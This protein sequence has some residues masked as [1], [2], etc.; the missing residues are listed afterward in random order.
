MHSREQSKLAHFLLCIP[1]VT[2][3]PVLITLHSNHCS[4][5]SIHMFE[6]RGC[7]DTCIYGYD[8][9]VTDT[10]PSCMTLTLVRPSGD[11]Y[12]TSMYDPHS[13]T[14]LMWQI[15]HLHAWPPLWYDPHVTDTAPP[16]MTLTQMRPSGDRYSTSMYDPPSGTTLRWQIYTAPPCMTLTL[17]Q[18][19]G[20]GYITSRHDPHSGTTLRWRI[21]VQ[22]RWATLSYSLWATIN[23]P[24]PASLSSPATSQFT[25]MTGTVW[26]A[27]F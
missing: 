18:P 22:I 25:F 27:P 21:Q 12:S 6:Q 10:A 19:T 5:T 14:T 11:G 26:R 15:Q 1:T 7:V 16:C 3:S 2:V 17:V 20:D 8:P 9:Q 24:V 23:S 13:D 4:P